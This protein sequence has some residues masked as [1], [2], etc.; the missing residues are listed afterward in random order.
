MFYFGFIHK[1]VMSLTKTL[2]RVLGGTWKKKT[3][4]NQTQKKTP[5]KTKKSNKKPAQKQTK[6]SLHWSAG[7]AA[8]K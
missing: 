8:R 5:Q 2:K 7:N 3:K 1:P 6:K 4:P